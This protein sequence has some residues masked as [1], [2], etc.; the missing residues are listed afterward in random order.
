MGV[1]AAWSGYGEGRPLTRWEGTV[2]QLCSC[3]AGGR[4]LPPYLNPCIHN[5]L[6]PAVAARSRHHVKSKKKKSHRPPP[7]S[8]GAASAASR[9]PGL[10]PDF[11]ATLQRLAL[12]QQLAVQ[13]AHHE[14][15]LQDMLHRFMAPP[16]AA[17]GGEGSSAS[18][19]NASDHTLQVGAAYTL[20]G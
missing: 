6:R 9:P 3:P 14:R 11:E 1:K 8:G 4:V 15:G 19:A 13:L 12:Q 16:A 7:S 20:A 5:L 18:L 10:Q 17:G 2:N